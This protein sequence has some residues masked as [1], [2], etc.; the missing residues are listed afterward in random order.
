MSG[1]ASGHT[2]TRQIPEQSAAARKLTATHK[3][4]VL[5]VFNDAD[6][7]CLVYQK[8]LKELL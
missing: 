8:A 4:S 1:L 2:W 7:K 6:L 5:S 3:R